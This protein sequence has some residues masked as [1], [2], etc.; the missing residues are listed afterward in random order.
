MNGGN[1]RSTWPPGMYRAVRR[2]PGVLRKLRI[3]GTLMPVVLTWLYEHW[4][5]PDGEHLLEQLQRLDV[6]EFMD[7]VAAGHTPMTA[8]IERE[9]RDFAARIRKAVRKAAWR[10]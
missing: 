10:N 5:S 4:D 8:A 7:E 6:Y 1:H 2:H 9:R 3:L